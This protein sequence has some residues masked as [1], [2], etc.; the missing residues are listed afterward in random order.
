M[1]AAQPLSEHPTEGYT[2]NYA[3][4]PRPEGQRGALEALSHIEDELRV[5]A[6]LLE[7]DRM[8]QSFA[9]ELAF[10][11]AVV[12]FCLTGEELPQVSDQRLG[13]H[14]ELVEAVQRLGPSF[15]EHYLPTLLEMTRD[16]LAARASLA[17]LPDPPKAGGL[18]RGAAVTDCGERKAGE[19][20]CENGSEKPENCSCLVYLYEGESPSG[21]SELRVYQLAEQGGTG[22]GVEFLLESSSPGSL[23]RSGDTLSELRWLS[24]AIREAIARIRQIEA[25]SDPGLTDEDPEPLFSER[26]GDQEVE[27]M[28]D[29]S[30]FVY[31]EQTSVDPMTVEQARWMRDSLTRMIDVAEARPRAAF[32][33]RDQRDETK[34][35]PEPSPPLWERALD[36]GGSV[37]LFDGEDGS[38]PVWASVILEHEV[39]E[40][41][42]DEVADLHRTLGEVLQVAAVETPERE[43]RA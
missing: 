26:S 38:S 4:P 27:L 22:E 25:G 37:R 23:A 29:G 13:H 32:E 28:P 10:A 5:L 12:R 24:I 31:A 18:A 42:L 14:A 11:V 43:A 7:S 40:L 35:D 16:M 3:T 15:P 1:S 30:V 8:R 33:S 39:C 36:T 19:G 2:F 17:D 34:E 9:F 6:T 21:C 20:V 41:S